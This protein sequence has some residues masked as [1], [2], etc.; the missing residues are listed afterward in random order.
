LHP[1]RDAALVKA[2]AVPPMRRWRGAAVLAA[3][4]AGA[5]VIDVVAGFP[6]FLTMMTL[7]YGGATLAVLGTRH[8]RRAQAMLASLP[9]PVEHDSKR[10]LQ[11]LEETGRRVASLT[12]E[13]RDDGVFMFDDWPRG[14][15]DATM[16]AHVLATL[17][18]EI[19]ATRG[20]VCAR[21]A[22]GPGGPV[23]GTL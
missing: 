3:I 9:F 5:A 20:V 13:L 4:T 7:S 21:V 23:R 11:E 10:T 2:P 17:G 15:R 22:W 14:R 16:L 8:Q 1:Y 19:H 6:L 18:N 12:F